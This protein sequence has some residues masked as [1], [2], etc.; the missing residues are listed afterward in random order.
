MKFKEIRLT[1][2]QK[3]IIEQAGGYGA[4]IANNLT[5]QSFLQNEYLDSCNNEDVLAVLESCIIEE[6]KYKNRRPVLQ[7]L[8]GKY[9]SVNRKVYLRKIQEAGGKI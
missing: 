9:M 6:I 1:G 2:E 4:I 5:V 7:R 3:F 8:F